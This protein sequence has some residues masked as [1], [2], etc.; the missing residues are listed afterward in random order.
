VDWDLTFPL[1]KDGDIRG[2]SEDDAAT[3]SHGG[4][5]SEGRRRM[6]WIWQHLGT[7][8]N[9]SEDTVHEGEWKLLSLCFPL[10]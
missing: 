10:L 3:A 5:M 2:L 6:S 4:Q 7:L 8:V 1:L 9:G